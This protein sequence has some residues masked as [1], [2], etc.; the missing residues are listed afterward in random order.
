MLSFIFLSCLTMA[1]TL[2]TVGFSKIGAVTIFPKDCSGFGEGARN[3]DGCF[4]CLSG[5]NTIQTIGPNL[6]SSNGQ[7][8]VLKSIGLEE[9]C[10]KI[11]FPCNFNPFVA[12]RRRNQRH[13]YAFLDPITKKETPFGCPQ[14]GNLNTNDLYLMNTTTP[15]I[16]QTD[17]LK[18]SKMVCTQVSML[19]FQNKRMVEVARL[20]DLDFND[21][22]PGGACYR[23]PLLMDP[24]LQLL[25]LIIPTENL[26]QVLQVDTQ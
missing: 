24:C 3:T 16:L 6:W 23:F 15:H 25:W 26:E 19:D 20:L 1:A 12:P 2:P 8:P 5:Y 4:F 7:G 9:V 13:V 11:P 22:K 10:K 21:C 17:T 18:C 14:N